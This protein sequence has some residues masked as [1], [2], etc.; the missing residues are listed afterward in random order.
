VNQDSIDTMN[1]DVVQLNAWLDKSHR[2]LLKTIVESGARPAGL[3]RQIESPIV[4]EYGAQLGYVTY[5]G[6][7]AGQNALLKSL[8]EVNVQ[9]NLCRCCLDT[10]DR[11]VRTLVVDTNGKLWPYLQEFTS[12]EA[13][14][15]GL[16]LGQYANSANSL[17]IENSLTLERAEAGTE[18]F[19][20]VQFDLTRR[21]DFRRRDGVA[22]KHIE[23]GFFVVEPTMFAG[24]QTIG[25][26]GHEYDRLMCSRFLG[27]KT[28]WAAAKQV[29]EA[30]GRV[31][32]AET[33]DDF[34]HLIDVL[35]GISGV[36]KVGRRKA[37]ISAQ[38]YLTLQYPSGMVWKVIEDLSDPKNVENLKSYTM[39]IM[40]LLDTLKYRRATVEASEREL[41]MAL[42][43]LTD[44]GLLSAL[45]RRMAA[46]ADISDTA[47][48]VRKPVT[49]GVKP[50]VIQQLIAEKAEKTDIVSKIVS[51]KPLSVQ[52]A[53]NRM[54]EADE[55]YVQ[56]AQNK[57]NW[58]CVSHITT[59]VD[60]TSGAILNTDDGTEKGSKF[61]G[62]S[63]RGVSHWHEMTDSGPG[64]YR[65]EGVLGH[66]STFNGGPE[67]GAAEG[68]SHEYLVFANGRDTPMLHTGLFSEVVRSDL[69]AHR[70][71]FE[72][73]N[74]RLLSA[75]GANVKD[76]LMVLRLQY[77][78]GDSGIHLVIG[79]GGAY[80]SHE[81]IDVE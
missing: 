15:L 59:A 54:A 62:Y 46:H 43:Q 31:N 75:P 55:I 67:H 7:T 25:R 51:G 80:T 6:F 76:A 35:S 52:T 14:E 70:R 4:T 77:C 73:I 33:V 13:A 10:V 68:D 20:Y 36:S 47:W 48:L 19:E 27:V 28:N 45:E 69:H 2:R 24:A 58:V 12:E 16:D 64:L 66:I 5:T 32:M 50:N 79:K 26:V 34:S 71:V 74:N 63:M 23:I 40:A 11:L 42:K 56:V 29:F 30:C 41:K 39:S 3:I 49:D 53:L 78:C 17:V 61:S 22:F 65:I 72:D 37:V 38:L 9:E 60:P 81:V 21:P 1:R 8:P 57:A 18:E 44:R